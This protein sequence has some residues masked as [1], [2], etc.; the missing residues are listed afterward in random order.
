MDSLAISQY[1]DIGALVIGQFKDILITYLVALQVMEGKMTLGMMLAI[2]YILGQI[3][4]PLQQLI[5]FIRE[6]QDAR[7]SLDRL[8]EI[9]TQKNEE[10]P[11]LE[12]LHQLPN[13]DII[14][15]NLSFKYTPIGDE[16]LSEINFRI[17]RGKTT[18]IVGASGSGK[19]TLVRLLLG[20]YEPLKGKI[21]VGSMP[22]AGI[23]ND[24]W[25]SKC[26]VVLQDG[27]VFSDTIA[28]NIAE[29]GDTIDLVQVMQASH[30]A[31]LD[32][33]IQSLPLG[34]QTTVGVKGNGL[35][36]GQKQRLLI[37]RA[38]YKNP[39]FIFFDEATNSLDAN[40]EKT[41]IQ[42]MNQFIKN[43]TAIIVA[44]R[45]STVRHADQ[46]IVL[47]RGKIVE[48]G[49]HTELVEKRGAYFELVQNQLELGE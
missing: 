7:I 15:D 13:G 27:F 18:A 49:T 26:G 34:Y 12:K 17:P 39:A 36:Q 43:R 35:S 5:G 37:A 30:T 41:I 4:G 44:H 11:E 29:S 3:N 33:F 10:L 9:H 1:Q 48:S 19:T 45:L 22:L 28:R 32:E 8:S 2:Q 20:F 14:I 21:M 46:I 24:Y 6:A 47:N 16:V 40:N 42:N 23:S 38:V 25:R 31:N